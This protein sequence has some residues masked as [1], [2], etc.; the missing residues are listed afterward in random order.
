MIELN[1]YYMGFFL[2][3]QKFQ[4]IYKLWPTESFAEPSQILGQL[5]FK[6]VYLYTSK[7]DPIWLFDIISSSKQVFYSIW[8]RLLHI[9]KPFFL[10]RPS[11]CTKSKLDNLLVGC[12]LAEQKNQNEA[13]CHDFFWNHSWWL[14]LSMH[15]STTFM[16]QSNFWRNISYFIFT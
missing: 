9:Q 6:T 15:I 4:H 16:L 13:C 14:L 12:H 2:F 3:V 5:Q 8:T 10:F 1:L 11:Y 7:T